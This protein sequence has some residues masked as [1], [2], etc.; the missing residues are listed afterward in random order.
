ME[1]NPKKRRLTFT[2]EDKFNIIRENGKT[3][4]VVCRE[5][6]LSKSTVATI[7]KNKEKLVA[8][9]EN[10]N[11]NVKNDRKSFHDDV[12]QALFKWFTQHRKN[13]IPISGSILQTK[14]QEFGT[15]LEREGNAFLCTA[16]WIE[17]W[18]KRHNVCS[19]KIVGEAA[20]VDE[21][22]VNDWLINK[23]PNIRENYSENDIFNGDETGLFFKLTPDKTLKFKEEKCTGGKLSK[24]RITILVCANLSGT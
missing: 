12:D 22:K 18:K 13:N 19:G 3:Q 20:V 9:Y 11:G 21:D 14:A 4:S 7:W 23:W 5:F 2:L 1:H 15:M 6:N 10:Q 16:S 17:R 24:E 8:A